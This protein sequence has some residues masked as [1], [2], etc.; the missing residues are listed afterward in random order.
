MFV[1]RQ[2]YLSNG[3]LT[4]HINANHHLQ[5]AKLNASESKILHSQIFY[6]IVQKILKKLVQDECYPDR[7]CSQFCAF[8]DPSGYN[9]IIPV[10]KSFN[11]YVEKFYTN[12]YNAS[13]DLEDPFRGLDLNCTCL[14]GFEVANHV[15]SYIT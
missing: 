3:G 4:R 1:L 2:I 13:V 14:E 11:G 12:Y 5:T 7:N 15:L 6:E 10:I 8:A 9:S